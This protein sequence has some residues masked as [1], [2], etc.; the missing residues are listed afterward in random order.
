MTK[1]KNTILIGKLL[2]MMITKRVDLLDFEHYNATEFTF[3]EFMDTLG[4]SKNDYETLLK[5]LNKLGYIIIKN[6]NDVQLLKSQELLLKMVE[7]QSN[8][9]TSAIQ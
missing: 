5:D 2:K 6:K 9:A 8:V 3:Y 1:E 4:L 7:I